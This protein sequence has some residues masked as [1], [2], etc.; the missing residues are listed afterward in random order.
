MTAPLSI[1]YEN[2]V[3]TYLQRLNT[4]LRSFTPAAGLEFI[5]TWVPDDDHLTSILSLLE[6]AKDEGPEKITVHVGPTTL[7][8]LDLPSLEQ[9]AGKLASI[10][11]VTRDGGVDIEA[12][13]KNPKLSQD[14]RSTS[15]NSSQKSPRKP[16]QVSTKRSSKRTKERNPRSQ[17]ISVAGGMAHP[18][19]KSGILSALETQ[20]HEGE[21]PLNDGQIK[22]E[23]TYQ[24][25]T[26]SASINPNEHTVDKVNFKGATTGIEKSLLEMLS[27]LMEGRPVVECA[28]HAV[29]NLEHAMR[30]QSTVRPVAGIVMPSNADPIFILPIKLVNGLIS[31]YRTQTD[32]WEIDNF[33][34]APASTWWRSLSKNARIQQ[35]QTMLNEHPSGRKLKVVRME[36]QQRVI[37]DFGD[38]PDYTTLPGRL[39]KLESHLQNSLEKTIQLHAEPRVDQNK[40]RRLAE[41]VT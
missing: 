36:G 8:N 7:G 25:V 17:Q 32:Y 16:N 12:D 9:A 21:T 34:T 24:G 27:G 2:L 28:H 14:P 38:D 40:L 13:F 3:Q 39:M 22:V 29:I 6:L 20:N 19:Y 35:V 30:D 37:V 1:D 33:Y 31:S 5:V 4:V 18:T 23:H 41:V 11:T 15:D 10:K 26:L